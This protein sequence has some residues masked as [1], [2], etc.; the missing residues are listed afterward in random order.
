MQVQDHVREGLGALGMLDKAGQGQK[1]TEGQA[2]Q[3]LGH[4]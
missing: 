4:T 2:T 1:V 3:H